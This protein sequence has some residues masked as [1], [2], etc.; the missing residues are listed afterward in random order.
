[1]KTLYLLRHAKSDWDNALQG[2]HERTL[3]PRGVK[4]AECV[5]RMLAA[6]GE[7]PDR[8]LTS[9][10][11]RARTT[12]DL[13]AESGGWDVP[14]IVV[15]EFYGSEPEVVMARVRRE[16]D[17]ARSLLLAGHEPVWSETTSELIG[18]GVL[19]FPTAALARVDLAIERWSELAPGRGQLTWFIIPRFVEAAG[20]GQRSTSTRA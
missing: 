20:L 16:A 3:A 10:A 19:R 11:V 4:A 18:G 1:M 12:V 8:V 2:D 13:A 7:I 9:S 6:A 17:D 14:T 15:P 5:G